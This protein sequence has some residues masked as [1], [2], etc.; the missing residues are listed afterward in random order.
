MGRLLLRGDLLEGQ[1]DGFCHVIYGR[2]SGIANC[3]SDGAELPTRP[4]TER[5]E[6]FGTLIREPG[7]HVTRW[8]R[9]QDSN[10]RSPVAGRGQA[11]GSNL[12]EDNRRRSESD[13]ATAFNGSKI[14]NTLTVSYGYF[15]RVL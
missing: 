3:G 10:P 15:H 5:D 2:S 9:D 6:I 13:R 7:L 12:Q 11:A 14:P 8:W 4:D 1:R